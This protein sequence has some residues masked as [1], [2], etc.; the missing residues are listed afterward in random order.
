MKK[1]TKNETKTD[2][3]GSLPP[4]HGSAPSFDSFW[5]DHDGGTATKEPAKQRSRCCNCKHASPGFRAFGRTHHHCEHP[6][7][8]DDEKGWGSLREWYSTCEKW[9]AK[10]PVSALPNVQAQRRPS[11]ITTL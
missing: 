2:G 4:A 8:T 11:N 6:T 10:Q 1:P 9:E 7:I 5:K 3:C